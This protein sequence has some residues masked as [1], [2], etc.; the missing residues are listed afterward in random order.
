M[1]FSSNPIQAPNQEVDEI[2]IIDPEIS[3]IRKKK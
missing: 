1:R 3:V 2:E